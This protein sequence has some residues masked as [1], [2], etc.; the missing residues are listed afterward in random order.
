MGFSL[1]SIGKVLSAPYTAFQSL[2]GGSVGDII[3]N[4]LTAAGGGMLGGALGAGSGSSLLNGIIQGAV[5]LG[6]DYLDSKMQLDNQKKILGWQLDNNLSLADRQFQHNQALAEQDY[7][8]NLEM[9]NYQNEYNSPSQQMARLRSAGLNPNLVYGG[10]NVSG[11]T[12]SD[13]PKMQSAQYQSPTMGRPE[14]PKERT[15]NRIM[16]AMSRYQQVENQQLTN[17]FTRQRIAL[18]ER[19]A[20][21]SDRLADAQIENMSSLYG[22][23]GSELGI[24][25]AEVVERQRE[26]AEQNAWRRYQDDLD[27][28]ERNLKDVPW[29]LKQ[30]YVKK[31]RKPMYMDYL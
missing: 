16:D 24:R 26:S 20:D 18:A 30:E 3:S 27:A 4:T 14:T 25:H 6:T 17:E 10:G 19:D 11:L 21:R 9:W 8:R 13:A 2:S 29:G 15:F 31:H 12:T 28:Y 22:L 1:G 5:G 23:R 7:Q